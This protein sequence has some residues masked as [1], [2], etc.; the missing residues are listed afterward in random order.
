[1]APIT[2]WGPLK[3]EGLLP[4]VNLSLYLSAIKFGMDG[5]MVGSW[6]QPLSA[7]TVGL[8]RVCRK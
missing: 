7:E 8:H 6:S 1:M 4:I 3:E 2:L 5:V